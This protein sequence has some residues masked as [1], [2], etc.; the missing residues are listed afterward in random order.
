LLVIS[1]AFQLVI[2]SKPT[3]HYQNLYKNYNLTKS[4][5]NLQ[6]FNGRINMDV[7]DQENGFMEIPHKADLALE[8]W[9]SSLSGLFTQAARGMVH[10]MQISS[11]TSKVADRKINLEEIDLEN[12]LV[13][14]LNEL[15][16]DIQ[17]NGCSYDQMDLEINHFSLK[18]KLTGKKIG[19]FN[20]EIKAATYH[21]LKIVEKI[22][23]YKTTITFDI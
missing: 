17:Q 4:L 3:N 5:F 11:S 14:F 8:V 10:L 1:R 16:A 2:G 21:D 20:R 15:L 12:L 6:F 18:G 7:Q 22:S 9:A 19:G 23:G 13:S